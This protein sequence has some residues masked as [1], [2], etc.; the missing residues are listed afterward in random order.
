[1][2]FKPEDA[3]TTQLNSSHTKFL[4]YWRLHNRRVRERKNR[5][6]SP[7][8]TED[9]Q[10]QS[11]FFDGLA[12]GFYRSTPE[13]KLL[14]INSAM[15]QILGYPND[16]I[17]LDTP[18]LDFYVDP[19]D[20]LRQQNT[21]A[22]TGVVP[23]S[24][25]RLRCYNGSIIWVRDTL[26]IRQ[27]NQGSFEYEGLLEDI[28]QKKLSEKA[29]QA[30]EANLWAVL[31]SALISYVLIDTN[32]FIREVN[33]TA[34]ETFENL[35]GITLEKGKS[36]LEII[37]A[38]YK[39][40]FLTYYHLALSGIPTVL[41]SNLI[42]FEG[43]EEWLEYHW[44]PAV[45]LT[46]SVIGICFSAILITSNKLAEQRIQELYE[47]ERHHRQ[48]AE[49]LRETGQVLGST[50]EVA[51]IL[52][53]ILE[54]ASKVVS[55][56]SGRVLLLENRQAV[57]SRVK[58]FGVF[59][60]LEIR[61]TASKILEIDQRPNLKWI[62]EH[63]Q[64][65]IIP[66]TAVFPGWQPISGHE[67]IRAWVG[68]PIMAHGEMIAIFSLDKAVPD[69]FTPEHVQF[70]T[71]LAG[72]T[73]LALENAILFETAQRRIREAD[74]LRQAAAAVTTELDLDHVLDRILINLNKVIQYDSAAIL[75]LETNQLEVVASLGFRNET[76]LVG[77]VFPADNPLFRQSLASGR[78][79]I[80]NDAASEI[81]FQKLLGDYPICGWL[82]VPLQLRGRAIGF[83]IIISY[84]TNIYNEIEAT[85]A[86]AFA[87]EATIALENAR[88]FREL[89]SLATTDPL[90]KVLNRRHFIHLAKIEFQRARRFHQPLSVILFDIDSFKTV[91]DTYGHAIG[92]QVL[93]CMAKICESNLRAVDLF[94]RY[95]GE[96]FM[97]LLP[98]TPLDGAQA[99]AER[100]RTEIAN[101]PMT[102]DR[103]MIYISASFGVAAMDD[104]CLD[105][106]TL[107]L[108]ADWATYAAKSEGKN[109]VATPFDDPSGDYYEFSDNK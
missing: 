58:G 7:P 24:E 47:S 1:M 9:F 51:V 108:H 85:L 4:K 109:R 70:L 50:L 36:V 45:T 19:E 49:I 107:L 91:N 29:L 18:I 96:E 77:Q 16:A 55:Y 33:N 25:I 97:A 79:I 105:I 56:D 66:D 98:N 20:R 46:G 11:N 62:V 15:V 69:F 10:T 35:L 76:K 93:Q 95:G 78:P 86:Q 65:L 72:Q 6:S 101:T 99:V 31:N 68:T 17:L 28:T 81:E 8:L 34:K 88:L 87:N 32:L 67:H 30:S 48:F 74:T 71:A 89:Q 104:T 106:D 100:L 44:N 3:R 90:T 80:V 94:G 63:G 26:R 83:L 52:D 12:I 14:E 103:G 13:G 75:L 64:P 23:Y 5:A 59:D 73:A 40:D 37:P 61:Q 92:D 82:G 22:E 84:T 57:I 43:R 27:N 54:Q 2:K 53:E 21:L 39:D 60:T 102:T 38:I 42:I 41:K